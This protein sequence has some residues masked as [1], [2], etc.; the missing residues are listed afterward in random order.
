MVLE[1]SPCVL[2]SYHDISEGHKI[3][4]WRGEVTMWSLLLVCLFIIPCRSP[5]HCT[6]LLRPLTLYCRACEAA[7]L[8]WLRR[9]DYQQVLVCQDLESLWWAQTNTHNSAHAHPHKH[10]CNSVVQVLMSFRSWEFS[11]SPFGHTEQENALHTFSPLIQPLHPHFT[12]TVWPALFGSCRSLSI[13]W[14]DDQY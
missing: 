12:S 5:F 9:H 8:E 11:F 1:C 14:S 7:G 3:K 4:G 6:K 2:C 10:G 13:C